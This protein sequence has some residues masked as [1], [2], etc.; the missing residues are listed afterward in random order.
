MAKF[1]KPQKGNPNQLVINQHTFPAKSIARFGGSSGRVQLQMKADKSIRLAKPSDTMF[2]ARR[3]WDHASE[4]RFIKKI[5]DN[6]QQLA[7]LIIDDGVSSFNEEQTHVI[8]SF[9]ALW[10]A[11]AQIRD[12]PERDAIMP[13]VWPGSALSKHQ[14]EGL[15]K[16]GYAFARGN[17][18]PA[19][20][21]NGV[22]IH[23]L[24]AR[25]LRQ[26]NATASWGIVRPSDG[27]FVVPDWPEHAFVPITPTIALANP[28]SNQQLDRS[29]VGLVNEQVRSA[30]RRYFF[31]RDFVA[32][33]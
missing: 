13:G 3:A 22:A 18:F 11:R 10:M 27:E 1:E 20:M 6:F 31:A 8:S 23:V 14:E 24:V 32:C 9:Y 7:D 2:C 5:E 12:Q 15:E 17:V 4:V 28:A 33:P 25:H 29:A 19:R 26:I 21:K 16:A 30:S